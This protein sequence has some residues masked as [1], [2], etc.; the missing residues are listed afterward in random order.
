MRSLLL[1][2]AILLGWQPPAL[3]AEP[4]R[5]VLII[6]DMGY[7]A[8]LGQRALQ[9]PGAVTYAFLPFTPSSVPQA[10]EAH[11]RGKEVMLHAPMAAKS[12]TRPGPGA[13]TPDMGMVEFHAVTK[14]IIDAV[15]HVRGVNNHMGSELTGQVEPM[16]WLMASLGQRGLYFVDSRTNPYT[17]AQKV[18]AL[19]GI[20]HLRRDVFLDDDND[21]AHIARQ[22]QL[23]L[24]RARNQGLAVAI[25]H[26]RPATL[27]VLEKALPAALAQP[28]IRLIPASRAVQ[29][30]YGPL[31]TV[32]T[33]DRFP[34]SR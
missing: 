15:P 14:S 16:Q 6:D 33:Q 32:L 31:L 23:L 1:L 34:T 27:A 26:P 19:N 24:V 2:M 17:V 18:A 25:G 8:S 22:F 28:D 4:V 12:G 5:I 11:A 30:G 20:P 10:N 21:P 9:L 7:S 29:R 13:L 3:A